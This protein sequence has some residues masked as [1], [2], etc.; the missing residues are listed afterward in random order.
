[1]SPLIRPLTALLI[2][3]G[4]SVHAQ[5]GG[6]QFIYPTFSWGVCENA[7]P[8][9]LRLY[10]ET[11]YNG[12]YTN[13]TYS[14]ATPALHGT[15]AISSAANFT[16]NP[17]FGVYQPNS[18][19]YTPNPG[20]AGTDVVV[21]QVTDGTL[22]SQMTLTLTVV[23]PPAQP[24]A[25]IG[26]DVDTVGLNT[27]RYSIDG[28]TDPNVNYQWSY[29]GS[30]VFIGGGYFPNT[31]NP[32][33][34]SFSPYPAA[35]SGVLSVV[36]TTICGTSAASSK[37]I[38]V[39]PL[40]FI[41]FDS[42][43]TPTYGDPDFYIGASATSTLEVRFVIADTTIARLTT[44]WTGRP[45][46][47]INKAGQ[48]TITAFQDGGR[49]LQAATPVTRTLLVKKKD[50]F[51]ISLQLP[52]T[53]ILGYDTPPT[54]KSTATSGL[55]VQ[56]SS[57]DTR[58]ATIDGDQLNFLDTGTVAITASQP[59]DNNYNAA[60][61]V[62]ATVLV[63]KP[64]KL[65]NGA[66]L[67]PNPSHGI[68]YCLPDQTFTAGAYILY[69]GN[70]QQVGANNRLY[71]YNHMFAVDARHVGPGIYYLKVFGGKDGK[72]A[73]LQFKVLIY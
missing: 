66:S 23:P 47:H 65:P 46:I 36:A 53:F 16:S 55:P 67:F 49:G 29:S 70:G 21:F 60:I 38:T 50:Q 4:L 57:S 2:L 48:T 15:A 27:V 14:V 44:D 71:Y 3:I 9:D 20:Y 32:V 41:K 64:A 19:T 33:D 22:S 39:Q 61:P 69:N 52:L 35:T 26:Q 25:I 43:P 28:P 30:Y 11:T 68:F 73:T 42:F 54:L 24:G 72:P 13:L 40:Q 31:G 7:S 62:T 1:M 51:I 8:Y 6:P 59:G 18:I 34:V 10:L 63:L 56:Y 5:T 37:A 58:I 45:Q 17:V 12:P